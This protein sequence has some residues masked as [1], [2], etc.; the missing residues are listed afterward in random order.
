MTPDCEMAMPASHTNGGWSL[1]FYSAASGNVEV[2]KFLLEMG[3]DIKRIDRQ[4]PLPRDHLASMPH[5]HF[6]SRPGECGPDCKEHVSGMGSL[7]TRTPRDRWR[8]RS[9][10]TSR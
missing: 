4:H 5:V 10:R 9:S 2:I 8:G 6:L 3:A 1:L 7:Q